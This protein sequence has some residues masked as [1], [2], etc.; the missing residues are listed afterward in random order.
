MIL[1]PL[2]CKGLSP[3]FDELFFLIAWLLS[4]FHRNVFLV[5]QHLRLLQRIPRKDYHSRNGWR[6]GVYTYGR[7]FRDYLL[8][9]RNEP[10]LSP[11]LTW[12]FVALQNREQFLL[13]FFEY[14]FCYTFWFDKYD[15]PM[16]LDFLIFILQSYIQ[17]FFQENDF[18]WLKIWR[19]W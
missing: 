13:I 1:L 4:I 15:R 2:K 5:E 14:P 12:F 9:K 10:S 3:K 8:K 6:R 11:C 19:W 17:T 18:D 16:R 7:K